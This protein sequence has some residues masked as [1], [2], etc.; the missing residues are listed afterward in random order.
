MFQ[1]DGV[2]NLFYVNCEDLKQIE[3]LDTC[4]IYI[5]KE[6]VSIKWTYLPMWQ[7]VF[8]GLEN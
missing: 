2:P 5:G 1:W 3:Y 6:N 4:L 8:S 7:K